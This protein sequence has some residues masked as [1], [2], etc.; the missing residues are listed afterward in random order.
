MTYQKKFC[1]IGVVVRGLKRVRDS[2]GEVPEI[3]RALLCQIVIKQTPS[4]DY[5]ASRPRPYHG[6]HENL[7]VGVDG[8]NLRG[9]LEHECPLSNAT[10]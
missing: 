6:V 7:S 10:C 1:T 2:G 8:G 3:T 5:I 4:F 9:T